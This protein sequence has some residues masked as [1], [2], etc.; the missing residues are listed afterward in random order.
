MPPDTNFPAYYLLPQISHACFTLASYRKQNTTKQNRTKQNTL[1]FLRICNFCSSVYFFLEY[2]SSSQLFT[3]FLLC[4][5]FCAKFAKRDHVYVKENIT[6]WSQ[7]P[8]RKS[9]SKLCFLAES[10]SLMT[11]CK[12]DTLASFFSPVFF[13]I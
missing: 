2:P 9:Q 12:I 1:Q 13:S 4:V 3:R 10:H 5:Y 11:L 7:K 8:V 6:K